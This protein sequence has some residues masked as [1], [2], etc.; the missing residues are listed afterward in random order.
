MNDEYL[1]PSDVARILKVSPR[2]VI[3]MI[4][5]GKLKAITITGEERKC[6]RILSGELDRFVAEEYQK[7]EKVEGERE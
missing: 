2:T 5:A 7:Y 1:K 6:Y 4:H 3:N